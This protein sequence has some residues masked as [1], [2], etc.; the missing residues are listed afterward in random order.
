VSGVVAI[1]AAVTKMFNSEDT[2]KQKGKA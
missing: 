2:K 1:A